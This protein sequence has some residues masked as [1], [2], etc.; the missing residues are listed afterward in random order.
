MKKLIAIVLLAGLFSSCVTNKSCHSKGH[1]V[2]K[3]VKKA[4][5]N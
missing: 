2:S 3:S 5:R 1:Y 4:Q